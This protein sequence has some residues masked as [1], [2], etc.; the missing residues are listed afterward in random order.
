MDLLLILQLLGFVSFLFICAKQDIKKQKVEGNDLICL[1]G[2][3][4]NFYLGLGVFIGRLLSCITFKGMPLIGFADIVVLC[5]I[6]L[7]SGLYVML[8]SF[9]L[10]SLFSML[11][12]GIFKKGTVSG[13]PFLLIGFLIS[14]GINYLL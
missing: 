6:Y 13:I 10:A 5:S 9:A 7:L 1:I 3:G 4:I 14:L 11:F 12:G 2:F 8:G